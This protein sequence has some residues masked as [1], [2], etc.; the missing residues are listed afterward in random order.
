M[1]KYSLAQEHRR[2]AKLKKKRKHRNDARFFSTSD[3]G[4]R[5][6]LKRLKGGITSRERALGLAIDREEFE[7]HG[8]P[9][10]SLGVISMKR[11][12]SWAN[13][14]FRAELRRD[15]RIGRARAAEKK[16]YGAK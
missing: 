14:I 3:E 12:W 15:E 13:T 1:K 11:A 10:C 2:Q 8:R 7:E 16:K 9:K 5:H 6:F 4:G